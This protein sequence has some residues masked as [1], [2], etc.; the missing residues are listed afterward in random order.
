M[1]GPEEDKLERRLSRKMDAKGSMDGSS[2]GEG[3]FTD[4]MDDDTSP[5]TD[6]INDEV[7]N[8]RLALSVG[9]MLVH[10]LALDDPFS[11]SCQ[12]SEA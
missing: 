10:T 7:L 3:E 5:Y 6:V 11:H 4:D 9:N 8:W 12:P 1:K 2:G